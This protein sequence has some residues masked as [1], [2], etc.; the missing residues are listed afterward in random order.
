MALMGLGHDVHLLMLPRATTDVRPVMLAFGA[1]F[2]PNFMR[3][4][5]L[6]TLLILSSLI[7]PRTLHAVDS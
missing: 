1:G 2:E 3:D 7:V 5:H 4:G 6:D